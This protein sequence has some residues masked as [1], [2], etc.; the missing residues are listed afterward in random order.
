MAQKCAI[1]NDELKNILVTRKKPWRVLFKDELSIYTR[2]EEFFNA[3]K[4]EDTNTI[5]PSEST[6]SMAYFAWKYNTC[7]KHI[8]QEDGSFL[9]FKF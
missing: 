5:Q 8:M 6:F 9:H 3:I 1:C 7:K 2:Q 4:C